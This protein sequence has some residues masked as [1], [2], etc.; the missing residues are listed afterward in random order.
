MVHGLD[1]FYAMVALAT[2]GAL[3]RATGHVLRRYALCG[4]ALMSLVS[5]LSLL[6]ILVGK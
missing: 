4:F 1:A 6:C 3:G 5:L 2:A